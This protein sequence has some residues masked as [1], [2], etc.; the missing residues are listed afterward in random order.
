MASQDAWSG[1][2][3]FAGI[4]IIIVGGMDMLQGFVAIFKDEYVVATPKGLAHP[5]RHRW[6][7]MSP[8]GAGC[9]S[10]PGSA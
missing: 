6:G 9:S 8:S 3:S 1:W 10:S 5:R 2:I 7:W 4:L